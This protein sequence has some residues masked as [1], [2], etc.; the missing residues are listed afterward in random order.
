[1]TGSLGRVFRDRRAVVL[2]LAVALLVNL[3]ILALVVLPSSNRVAR[4]EQQ[5]LTARQ[6]LANAQREF[7]A[8]SRTQ[9]DKTRAEQDLQK[10]Y[11]E[12]LPADLAGA[13]RATYVHLARLAQDAGL[14]YERRLEESREPKQGDQEPTSTLA[15][16]DITMVLKGDYEG[17][18]QFLRDVEGSD[19]FIVIE[20]LGLA[21]GA[22]AGADLV[23]TVNLST[24]Y[25]AE[26]RGS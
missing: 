22:E 17:V 23:L 8:A 1:M 7:T 15:R 20:N 5:E 2:P 12:V 3:V 10:F 11:S 19:S 6:D 26:I 4:T 25:R 21:Q 24:F 13:R 9:Q 16:F 18:R 14:R